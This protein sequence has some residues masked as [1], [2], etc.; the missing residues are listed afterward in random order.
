MVAGQH[1]QHK[2]G[3]QL[4]R[5]SQVNTQHEASSTLARETRLLRSE[6][7]LLVHEVR[8]LREALKY[9]PVDNNLT[10]T[11]AEFQD[12][13]TLWEQALVGKTFAWC[14][15]GHR[16]TGEISFEALG[17]TGRMAPTWSLTRWR[18]AGPHEV[19]L[20]SNDGANPHHLYFN[21]KRTG[22]FC[23]QSGQRGYLEGCGFVSADMAGAPCG[24]KEAGL[25]IEAC[26]VDAPQA[27]PAPRS[28]QHIEDRRPP[29]MERTLQEL[30]EQIMT[31]RMLP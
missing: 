15:G 1:W 31:R 2:R 29:D 20:E 11:T 3:R 4:R 9:Q 18:I 7:T 27:E 5:R 21:A 23:E 17:R 13:P 28:H 19:V 16:K 30:Y 24:A 12:L 8:K 26:R 22:F 14:H 6:V 10:D 25:D